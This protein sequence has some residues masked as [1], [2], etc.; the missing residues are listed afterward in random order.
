MFA[1]ES[2]NNISQPPR[3]TIINIKEEPRNRVFGMA[4]AYPELDEMMLQP[5]VHFSDI[6]LYPFFFNFNFIIIIIILFI[7]RLALKK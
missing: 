7:S 4:R 6:N 2:N 1:V 3:P 5:I